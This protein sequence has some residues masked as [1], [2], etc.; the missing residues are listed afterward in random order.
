M[1]LPSAGVFVKLHAGMGWGE[2]PSSC[3]SWLRPEA[4]RHTLAPF[5]KCP[6]RRAND[7]GAGTRVATLMR[8][9]GYLC[10][11]SARPFGASTERSRM[12]ANRPGSRALAR[13]AEAFSANGE[14]LTAG[15]RRFELSA[16]VASPGTS[17]LPGHAQPKR[18]QD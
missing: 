3:W 17:S 8:S 7:P 16:L 5:I 2:P 1:A 13:H 15:A 14:L 4:R 11:S 18:G 10:L 9:A 12:L 6:R